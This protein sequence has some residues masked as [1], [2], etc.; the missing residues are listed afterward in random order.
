MVVISMLRHLVGHHADPFMTVAGPA[1]VD[2]P[3]VPTITI[4]LTEVAEQVG[5]LATVVRVEMD[6]VHRG[7]LAEIIKTFHYTETWLHK[8]VKVVEAAGAE[9]LPVFM[10]YAVGQCV[11]EEV[12][13]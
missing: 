2:N 13:E 4:M 12:V 9:E 5:I 3:G 11:L 7:I 6:L 10:E 1:V 8:L